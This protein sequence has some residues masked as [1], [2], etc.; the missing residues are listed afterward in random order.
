MQP[1]KRYSMF[2]EITLVEMLHRKPGLNIIRTLLYC[3]F[4][5]YMYWWDGHIIRGEKYTKMLI[6]V[7]I[8]R[9]CVMNDLYF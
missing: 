9:R 1:L 8:F 2:M 5:F 3:M 4:I 7:V 6:R